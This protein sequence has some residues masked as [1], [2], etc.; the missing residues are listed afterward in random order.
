MGKEYIDEAAI[1]TK[2][3]DLLDGFELVDNNSRSVVYRTI[4][5]SK[6]EILKSG[7]GMVFCF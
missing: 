3:C 2:K 1:Y 4:T 5:I 7:F 6:P